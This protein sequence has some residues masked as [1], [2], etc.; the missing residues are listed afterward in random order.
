MSYIAGN[1]IEMITLMYHCSS[2]D[3]SSDRMGFLV[4]KIALNYIFFTY[5]L[6]SRHSTNCFILINWPIVH[7]L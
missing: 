4:R 3:A 6:T 1:V 5:T 7:A 2:R